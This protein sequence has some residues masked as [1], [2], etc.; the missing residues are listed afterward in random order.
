M[1]TF[2]LVTC[3][4]TGQEGHLSRGCR[5]TVTPLTELLGTEP[6][7]PL[8]V[9]GSEIPCDEWIETELYLDCHPENRL[10]VLMLVSSNPSVA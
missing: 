1:C 6:L 9:N 4:D 7:V 3:V 5:Q 8:A 2:S 10:L